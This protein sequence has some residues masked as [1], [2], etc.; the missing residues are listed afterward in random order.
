M[1]TPSWCHP[2]PATAM[3][4]TPISRA[5]PSATPHSQATLRPSCRGVFELSEFITSHLGIT[6]VGAY[7][8]HRVT[9][10]A[11]CNSLRALALGEGPKSL[12]RAVKGIEFVDLPARRRSVAVSAA[13]SPS[14]TRKSP[15]PCSPT[16][17]APCWKT[18]AEIV[19]AGRQLLPH[20]HRR[21]PVACQGR[22]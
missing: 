11:S 8:P 1:P 21:R 17:C 16:R 6:D 10:H 7:F 12:L 15:P 22:P 4:R 9:Y 18:R 13:R 2:H 19:T 20:A 5:S 14:R 3:I